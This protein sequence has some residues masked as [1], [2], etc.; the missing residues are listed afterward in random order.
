MSAKPLEPPA[1]QGPN[2][3]VSPPG[4]AVP[5]DAC[6][7]HAHVIGP[8]D[9]FPMVANRSYTPPAGAGSRLS[10]HARQPRHGAWRADPDQRLRHRQP[11]HDREPEGASGP[12]A[13]RCGG[14]ARCRRR[15]T[16][17]AACG[18]RARHPHQRIVRRRRGDRR[19]GAAGRPRRAARLAY[20]ALDRCAQPARTRPAHREA[21]G[22]GR[23]RPY[24]SHAGVFR[25]RRIPASSGCCGC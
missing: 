24:G 15:R 3:F 25:R 22:R 4:F 1:C 13:R 8:A 19:D 10:R 12:A 9:R 11:L 16:R 17:S 23:D 20:P 2:P 18:R 21:A 14:G 6:D 5:A 7:T